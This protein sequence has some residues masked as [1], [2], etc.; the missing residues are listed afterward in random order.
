MTDKTTRHERVEDELTDKG[1]K[2]RVSGAADQLSGK[3]RNALGAVTGDSAQQLKGKAQELKG[4]AK[5][6][7]GKAQMDAA[8]AIEHSDERKRNR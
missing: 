8:R 1:L 5:D 3:T 4:E 6:A 7:L 2:N